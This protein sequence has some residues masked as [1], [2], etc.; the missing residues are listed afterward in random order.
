MAT[1]RPFP[2][3]SVVRLE[4]N[5]TD[6]MYE[7][8]GITNTAGDNIQR[9]ILVTFNVVDYQDRQM[10]FKQQCYYCGTQVLSVNSEFHLSPKNATI[11]IEYQCECVYQRFT[12]ETLQIEW[13]R[14]E[15]RVMA[16]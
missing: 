5:Q 3:S 15:K 8:S 1:D 11:K 9:K 14:L 13:G 6:P 10:L 4:V 12:F 2:M 7:N 16:L